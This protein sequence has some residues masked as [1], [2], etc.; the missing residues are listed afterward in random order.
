MNDANNG[1]KLYLYSITTV[2]ILGGLLFGYDTAVISGAEKGLEAFFL[3]A[4]DFQYDKVMHGINFFQRTYRLCDRWCSFRFLRFP[5]GTTQF[6][7]IGIRAVL[8]VCIGF[9]LSRIFILQLR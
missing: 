1:S 7:E 2:A 8:P 5:P 9:L 4:T 6:V 3:M